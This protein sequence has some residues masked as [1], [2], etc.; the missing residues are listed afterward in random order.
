MA[1][2]TLNLGPALHSRFEPASRFV[3]DPICM[4]CKDLQEIQ[5]LV[6]GGA[7]PRGDKNKLK[8]GGRRLQ[9]LMQLLDGVSKQVDT[10]VNHLKRTR[11]PGPERG[12]RR[13]APLPLGYR[14]HAVIEESE[15]G[16]GKLLG[17]HRGLTFVH[18]RCRNVQ[19]HSIPRTSKGSR[20]RLRRSRTRSAYLHS[21][22]RCQ[23][24]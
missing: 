3:A 5:H 21:V 22:E 19:L 24:G 6:A 8:D 18:R 10:F 9:H 13:L 14:R 11:H 16:V 15:V 4:E 7:E 1:A 2:S 20:S 12:T 23:P 17:A